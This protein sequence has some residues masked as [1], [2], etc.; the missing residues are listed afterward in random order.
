MINILHINDKIESSGGVETNIKD[1]CDLAPDYKM[2]MYWLGI[3]EGDK[4]FTIKLASKSPQG[5][6]NEKLTKCIE[7]I[8]N[9]CENKAIDI[10]HVHSISNPNLLDELFKIRPVVRSMHEPRMVCPG[11]GKFFRNS[12]KVCIKPF[13]LRCFYNA[14]KEGCCNRNPK[15][16]FKAYNNVVFETNIASSRYAAIIVM[17]NYMFD[18]ALK[19]GFTKSNLVL[20]PYFTAALG[21]GNLIDSSNDDVKSLVY[22]GRLSKTKGVHYAIKSVITLLEQGYLVKFDIVG[23]GHDENYF[24]TIIPEQYSSQFI[25]HGWQD[26]EST[27]LILRKAYIVLFPSIYPE[28][29]GISGIEAMMR[30][31]PVVGFNVG[32]V[33]T[34][35]EDQETGFIV[36]HKSIL[37][38]SAKVARLIDDV[39]LYRRLSINSR[40]NAVSKFSEKRHMNLLK[41]TYNKTLFYESR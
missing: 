8:F 28:A 38:M 35:L 13:G 10:I 36:E 31:K 6:P 25:F 12:E 39:A 7:F 19:A 5:K 27:D 11:Q 33:S 17:S 26:R 22:V 32:G 2:E 29:F 41:S 14:Y 9:F 23:S 18:E 20:N 16:L 30:A 3:Y 15:R 34:W 24:K 1:L 21:K 4:G 37:Q 40:D